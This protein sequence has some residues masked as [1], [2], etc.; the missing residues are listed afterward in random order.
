M[1]WNVFRAKS[2]RM[3]NHSVELW[4]IHYMVLMLRSSISFHL[5][6]RRR[7]LKLAGDTSAR[8]V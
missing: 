3:H 6:L 8:A 7:L 2:E 4:I 5:L 1:Q